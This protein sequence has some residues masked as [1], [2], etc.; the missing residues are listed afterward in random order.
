[1]DFY[2]YE[3][4]QLI[5][6]VTQ[7]EVYQAY[8]HLEQYQYRIS[9]LPRLKR[10]LLSPNFIKAPFQLKYAKINNWKKRNRSVK[11]QMAKTT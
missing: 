9:Q 5:D 10:Y 4:L 8:P 2:L 3:L 6:Y 11:R 7:G 1:M